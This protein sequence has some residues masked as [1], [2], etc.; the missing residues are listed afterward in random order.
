[1][2]SHD[3][4]FSLFLHKA[5]AHG[6]KVAFVL[7][8]LSLSYEIV[9]VDVAKNE[10]KSPE[11]MKLNPNGRTPALIDHGNSDFVIWES[12]AMVQYVADKYD[13]ERKISMAPGT[14]DFYIQLQ[15]QYFQ[16]TGQG[17]YFGQLVWFTLY[18]EEKIPSA[19]TRYKEE[20][21]RVF[22]VLERVLSNQ[23]WLVGGKMTI[24][25]ISF[26]SWNDM[27][28]HFLDNFDFEKEFP[29]T[30]AWHYKML[31]RPTI[32]RPWDERRKLMSRQ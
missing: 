6:W 9:L 1:M 4:Q 20:A 29:A 21:L 14:D 23:E 7:E 32:K 31:K 30:A 8:E 15:W 18:H 25:D 12:N 19:V 27:I 16:G 13:T 10:Q 5:S 22:S 2:A 11:F 3:K 24:A 17:P 26:V 28:V